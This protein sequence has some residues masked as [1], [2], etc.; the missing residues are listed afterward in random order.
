[1]PTR[2]TCASVDWGASSS[3]VVCTD[4]SLTGNCRMDRRRETKVQA[5][6]VLEY[7]SFL[8]FIPANTATGEKI[9]DSDLILS[10]VYPCVEPS[11]GWKGQKC[12]TSHCLG[13]APDCCELFAFPAVVSVCGTDWMEAVLVWLTIS[14]PTGRRKSTL[15]QFLRDLL[16]Q[17]RHSVKCSGTHA[18]VMIE[19]WL[20][21]L[22]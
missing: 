7:W 19:P 18:H 2:Y 12:S 3:E 16:C 15:Y 11:T 14:M 8:G 6:Q 9:N 17:V 1:M 4:M 10:L 13:W 5:G 22:Y 20:Q 21:D